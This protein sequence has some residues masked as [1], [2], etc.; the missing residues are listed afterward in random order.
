MLKPKLLD[1]VRDAIM[2]KARRMMTEEA[3][4][5]WIKQCILFML[6]Q[7]YSLN[8]TFCATPYA[9][10][11]RQSWKMLNVPVQSGTSGP[12]RNF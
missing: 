11:K 1:Q 5:Y 8:Q 7:T 6:V 4:V 3:Y 9:L 12:A 2:G 10:N